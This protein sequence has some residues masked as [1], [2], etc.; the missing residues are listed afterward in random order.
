[1]LVVFG[2][3]KYDT[4][5]AAGTFTDTILALCDD[6]PDLRRSTPRAWELLG[7]WL[8]LMPFSNHVPCPPALLLAMV[9]LAFVYKWIDAALYL[10]VAW[11]G[12]LRPIECLRLLR[13]DIL[14][15]SELLFM[16]RAVFLQI[17]SPKMR[18]P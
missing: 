13:S 2:Q 11:M 18:R 5:Y 6:S 15:P 9:S 10:L 7:N 14:L 4:G 8:A 1:M 16:E 3:E 17:R 12:V